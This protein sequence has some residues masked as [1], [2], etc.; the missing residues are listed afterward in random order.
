MPLTETARTPRLSIVVP[1]HRVQGYLRACLDSV[2]QQRFTDFEIVVVDDA[3]PDACGAIIDEYAEQDGRVVPVHLTENVGIGPARDVGVDR[4][5]GAYLFFLDSDDTL[6]SGAL[7]A[8]AA[9]LDVTADP[10][11]LLF[12]HVRTYWSG[13]VTP[14]AAGELLAAGDGEVF[15]ML[16]RPEYLRAFAVVWNRV[17]RRDFYVDGGH[18]FTDGIYEDALMVY[19]TMLSAERIACLNQV[20]VEYRQR[21]QGNSMRTPGRKHFGI[22]E[23]YDRLMAFL[24][25]RPHLETLR[26]LLF[27]RMISHF[28]F[29]LWHESRVPA[30]ARRD[31]FRQAARRYRERKPSGFQRPDGGTGL[32][33]GLLDRGSYPVYRATRLLGAAR[34]GARR[35][36][37]RA[38]R[39]LGRRAYRALYALHRRRPL[40]PRLAVYSAYWSRGFSCNPAAVHRKAEELAPDVHGVWL[41][42][43][44][45]ASA[46]PS[47]V[48]RVVVGSRRYWQV[49]ARAKYL[50]NNVNFPDQIVK[51]PGQVHLQTHHGTPLKHMGTD[52]QHRPATARSMDFG[53]LLTRSDRWDV[54][55][56][57]NQHSAEVWERV[58]PCGFENLASGYPRNDVYF[59]ATAD[60]VRRSR[61]ALGIEDG[62][63]AILYAPTAREHQNGF[64]P[65]LDLER[66]CR[67]LGPGYVLLVRA[68]YFYDSG[69][70]REALQ[71]LEQQGMLKDVSRHPVVEEL[72]L[73]ADAL[74]T[75]YSSVMFD[76]ACLDRPIVV[77]AD[78]WEVYRRTRGVYF[79]LLSGKAGE[80]P[81]CVT[82]DLEG[83]V[84]A[85]RSG[86]WEGPEAAELRT[87][88]RRRFVQY[89]DGNAAE[90]V[91]RKVFLGEEAALPVV[92]LEE[93]TPAPA[94][95][96][97][98]AGVLTP[99]G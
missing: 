35:T 21:R 29:T 61:E 2:L 9:R 32:K 8:I 86:A 99:A 55:L 47:G 81:G 24:D 50:V 42:R 62:R 46:M 44:G 38:R 70:Q 60:D 72:C 66:L 79:D 59:T 88:F 31:F 4:S 10:D 26:P 95:G 53:K 6:A 89:D 41:V 15:D 93:R 67:E 96:R 49:M 23:Q 94:P 33:F 69:R 20:C 74:V 37:A 65:P 17:F 36:V 16:E 84:D 22:F 82:H 71:A 98:V 68:H 91:V 63:T 52:Q 25:E 11:I 39:Y 28:L 43:K 83:L 12:D 30:S 75:D 54:S 78:D 73:A 51:R 76:Y 19:Q 64:V 27:E 40:D 56:S 13:A 7:E 90:R 87:A 85:F 18:R 80:T 57:S 48:D 5:S 58:Y 3:S 97:A 45:D 77:L 92:P 14:S 1:V 34:R